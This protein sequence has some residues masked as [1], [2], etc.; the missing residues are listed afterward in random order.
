MDAISYKYDQIPIGGALMT[1]LIKS[2]SLNGHDLHFL[3]Y[4][5]QTETH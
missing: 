2:N 5:D 3:K 4:N 1:V